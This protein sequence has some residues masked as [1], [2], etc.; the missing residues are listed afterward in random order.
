MSRYFAT[1]R[2]GHSNTQLQHQF[3]G[4]SLLAP[5]QVLPVHF[6]NQYPDILRQRRATRWTRLPSPENTEGLPMP[7]QKCIGLYNDQCISPGKQAAQS[8]HCPAKRNRRGPT[9]CL[10]F[11]IKGELL[12]EK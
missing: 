4:N 11:L 1:V 6:S 12:P 10:T 7:T 5:S 9:L 2:G 3:I 8:R